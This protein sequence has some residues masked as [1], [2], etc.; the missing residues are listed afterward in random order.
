MTIMQKTLEEKLLNGTGD[1]F[2]IY[3]LRRDDDRFCNLELLRQKKIEPKREQ[4]A[5]VYIGAL[6]ADTGLESIWET[7]NID[8]PDDYF[9]ASL[10]V[11]DIVVLRR[12]G[13]LSAHFVNSAGFTDLPDFFPSPLFKAKRHEPIKCLSCGKEQ[14]YIDSELYCS[15]CSALIGLLGGGLTL[16]RL[17]LNFWEGCF[18]CGA[19]IIAMIDLE[20]D[21]LIVQCDNCGETHVV[22]FAS[23]DIVRYIRSGIVREIGA[24]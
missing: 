5:L 3:R 15:R 4:Y 16:D 7:F 23:E 14:E 9:S 8:H 6:P 12:G 18:H 19:N 2:G 20:G 22:P 11:G 1:L 13:D 17:A 21:H 10:S 24:D